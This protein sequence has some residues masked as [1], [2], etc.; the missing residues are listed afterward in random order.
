M[1]E[2]PSC[3]RQ[4]RRCSARSIAVEHTLSPI[5][6]ICP[7]S[8]LPPTS[9]ILS[10]TW[11]GFWRVCGSCSPWGSLWGT[12]CA[13]IRAWWLGSL[14]R[15]ISRWIPSI[16]PGLLYRWR[17]RWHRVAS[18]CA[19]IGKEWSL[20]V[21]LHNT[22]EHSILR[23]I[24]CRTTDLLRRRATYR[25]SYRE[26]TLCDMLSVFCCWEVWRIEPSS[27][28]RILRLH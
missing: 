15:L 27:R 26:C 20:H 25:A 5:D 4:R 3:G 21:E 28:M 1:S 6:C 7:L 12:R 13:R 11:E 17:D 2:C 16:E 22:W 19:C 14:A 8:S 9:T 23:T 10:C 24:S 18:G